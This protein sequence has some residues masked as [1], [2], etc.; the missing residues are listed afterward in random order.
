MDESFLL[1]GTYRISKPPSQGE[2][3]RDLADN[4]TFGRQVVYLTLANE[5]ML[6]M[7]VESVHRQTDGDSPY[8][9]GRLGDGGTVVRIDVISDSSIHPDDRSLSATILNKI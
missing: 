1:S 4:A 3:M 7:V 6:S 9:M 2:L 8:V 5:V